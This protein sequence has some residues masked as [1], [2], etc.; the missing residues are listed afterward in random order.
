[1]AI[2]K[3]QDQ[4][5]HELV[6]SSMG[7]ETYPSIRKMITEVAGLAYKCVQNLFRTGQAL[8]KMVTTL[9]LKKS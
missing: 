5:L 7:F 2:N 1:M 4:A 3:I 8:S 9:D 6:D